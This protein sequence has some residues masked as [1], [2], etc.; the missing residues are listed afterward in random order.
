MTTTINIPRPDTRARTGVCGVPDGAAPHLSIIVP[1]YNEEKRLPRSLERLERYV[2]RLD[3]AVEVVV[4]ENGS[5]DGTGD[6]VRDFQRRMPYLRLLHEASPGKGGAVRR[7]MLAATGRYLM[8]CDADF[9]MPVE[10]IDRFLAVLDTGAP[11]VI[12]SRELPASR[13]HDEPARRHVMGR[14]YNRI[15]RA[16]VVGGI[17]DTQCGFK[18]FQRPVGRDLFGLQRTR[19]WAFD[20]EI[21]YLAQRRGYAVHQVPIDWYYDGDSRVQHLSDSLAMLGETLRIRAYAAL[22]LYR[23][24]RPATVP[25]AEP[26]TGARESG[27]P[28]L[29]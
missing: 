5:T 13:R 18:A 12:A 7:G 15:V 2:A 17:D 4:V 19:G 26:M 21:L 16:L 10:E 24:R 14:V 1:A 23:R 25:A 3:R 9:S 28:G 6:V 29:V 20:A 8:F 22:R 11:I 27:L